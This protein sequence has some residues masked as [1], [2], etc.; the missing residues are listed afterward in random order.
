VQ[1]YVQLTVQDTGAGIAQPFLPHVFNRFWQ[2]DSSMT[3]A[4][5]GL[6]LGL[7]IVRHLVEVH[8]GTVS[9]ESEGEGRGALFSVRMPLRAVAPDASPQ[10]EGPQAVAAREPEAPAADLLGGL[11]VLVVDDEAD[12][13]DLVAA[14]L[15]SCGAT[16]RAAAS[17]E[18]AIAMLKQ[19][20][21]DVV[22]SDIGLPGEDGLALIRRVREIDR[23]LPAA[24]L[25]AYAGPDDRR[26]ALVAG[27]QAH[28]SKPVEPSEL[29]LLVASLAGR[30]PPPAA[31]E[32][33]EERQRA[34][35]G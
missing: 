13:R 28:V 26:R 9:A 15:A 35:P 30:A 32:G 29:A 8:G 16:V 1:S 20:R 12:A 5:G 31:A 2:A 14:V 11:D 27:F 17:V 10:K 24:A 33:G 7:A 23:D 18:E 6:G 25:T 19:Q 34:V 4:Q 21:P 22:L 3:R